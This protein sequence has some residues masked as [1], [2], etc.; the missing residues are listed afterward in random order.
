[1]TEQ[2]TT[3]KPITPDIPLGLKEE[4]SPETIAARAEYHKSLTA[5]LLGLPYEDVENLTNLAKNPDITTCFLSDLHRTVAEEDDPV[6][7]TNFHAEL[8]TYSHKPVHSSV[9]A[10]S[11][12][13][14]S[15]G[16]TEVTNYF[17]DEDVVIIGS[18]SPK[19]ISHD[20]GEL[21]TLTDDGK[22]IP[23]DL[24]DTP[25]KPKKRDYD[26]AEEF[27]ADYERYKM[28]SK[29][30]EQKIKNCYHLIC[31]TGKIYVFLETVTQA[32]LEMFKSVMSQDK[33]RITHKYVDDRGKVHKTVLEGSPAF[34]FCSVDKSFN[35]EFA[36]RVFTVSP[37]TEQ[38][39]IENAKGIKSKKC[40]FPWE[41]QEETNTKML[42]KA[43]IRNIRDIFKKYN[44]KIVIPF[45]NLDHLFSSSS[46]RDMRDYEHFTQILPSYTML[47]LFQRPIITI[48]NQK[49]LVVALED[50]KEAKELFDSISETTKTNTDIK[51]LNFYREFVKN[52]KSGVTLETLVD[53]YN[54][55]NPENPLSD[56]AIRWYLKRLNHL[57]WV[58]IKK[59]QQEDKRKDTFYPLS[60]S[61]KKLDETSGKN[62]F[63]LVLAPKLQ[64]GFKTW[65]ETISKEGLI[66][67]CET[68]E[69]LDRSL[70]P[71]STEDFIKNI[72]GVDAATLLIV[73]E[74][75]IKPEPENESKTSGKPE[76]QPVS[77][78]LIT[79]PNVN[80]E[81]YKDRFCGTD[82]GSFNETGCPWF[83]HK[84][85]KDKSMPMKCVGWKAPLPTEEI[86]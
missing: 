8:S 71:M 58:Q 56:Y 19:V 57:G 3:S 32:T 69:L 11:G 66:T 81:V 70:K 83:I 80:P 60:T 6:S 41:Y 85:P 65:L 10:E 26:D 13:G 31:L 21:M 68:I 49:Y 34:I 84:I 36:T 42:I 33:P 51:I 47:K 20:Y 82:C 50:V 24:A 29:D 12:A 43:L 75:E 45:P 40:S 46:T 22:E 7:K 28:A 77:T 1:L 62:A 48:K 35:A 52:K 2:P 17:P 14:K 72:S 38:K 23:L 9:K 37:T 5:E 25:I 27:R 4:L 78:I 79:V 18:Q 54:T 64:K 61:Q 67:Q 59:G 44:L 30:W 39:K 55:S 16:V 73:S 86:S 15:Y 63:Q 76:N 53:N 74:A